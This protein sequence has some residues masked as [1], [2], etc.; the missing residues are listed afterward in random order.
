MPDGGRWRQ[1]ERP[2]GRTLEVL[3]D[4][5]AVGRPLV[6]H[7]GTPSGAVWFG[8]LA[9]AASRAGLRLVTYSRPGYAGSTPM[10]GRSVVDAAADVTAILDALGA[11]D[12]LTAGWSGGGPHALAC[13]ALLSDRCA[14]AASIAG[15]APY[16]AE[17]LDWMAGMGQD[18]V[19]E[20]S[21]ALGG[22]EAL[23]PVLE[24]WAS[25]LAA[26]RGPDVAE[27]LRT[28]VSD[29]DKRALTGEFAEMLAES[30]RRAVSKGVAGWLDDDLAFTRPWGF[31]LGSIR[32][33]VA[34]WQGD[35]DRMVPFGHGA[36]LAERIPGARVHLQPEEGHLSL[37]VASLEP[38]IADLKTIG[39]GA[40]AIRR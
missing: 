40:S 4:G 16:P 21:A 23:R 24:K 11:D 30:F 8:Q 36:W 29:V 32:R 35:Q 6:F 27:S 19:D 9:E 3:V 13:A 20:F 5:E 2:G 10:P 7:W 26:V 31:S 22:K 37:A 38:I 25:E 17:G 39:A 33:P 18:N 34:V 12:F 14:A 15:V 28:L 1:V